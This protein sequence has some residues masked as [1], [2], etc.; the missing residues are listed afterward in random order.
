S[1]GIGYLPDAGATGPS[2]EAG[3]TWPTGSPWQTVATGAP[4]GPGLSGVSGAT[5]PTGERGAQLAR[6]QRQWNDL[7]RQVE[8][9]RR[10]REAL[11]EQHDADAPRAG[12]A[13]GVVEHE[14]V[15]HAC[16]ATS[17]PRSSGRTNIGTQ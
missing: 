11:L 9:A 2:G 12:G 6:L 3:P 7:T 1:S 10:P 5:R 14:L 17:R 16:S 8:H 13:G 4:G 15:R